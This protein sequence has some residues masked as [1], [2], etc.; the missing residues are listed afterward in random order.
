MKKR[1]ISLLLV[2]VMVLSMFPTTVFAARTG[3]TAPANQANPF[4]D[5]PEGTWFYDAV[6]YS[7][8]NGFFKGTSE[9][10]FDP[11]G[12]MTRGMFVTVLGRMAGVDPDDYKGE[13]EF[14]DV[15]EH[16]YYAPYIKWAARYGITNGTGAGMFAPDVFVNR[17]QM[18]T[19]F[20]RYLETFDVDYQ[21][22]VNITTL[23]EDLD[24]VSPY[25][26][27]AVLKLWKLGLL[28][29]DGI[30]F[31]PIATS[32]RAQIATLCMRTD[33]TVD[34]WYKEPGVIGRDNR[35]T[36]TYSVR[37][38]DGDRLID[39]LTAEEGEPLGAVPAV[40]KSSKANAILLGYFTDP[41]C[42]Q[43]FYA[44]NPVTGDMNVYAKY[45]E[46]G[47][48]EVLNF[49]SFAQMDQTPD[50]SFEVVGT[51]DPT[52]AITLEVKDGSDP[53]ALKFEATQG[54]YIVSAEGGFNEGCS[55]ELHLAD[56]WTFKDKPETVRTA[57]FSIAMEQV[58]N[59][60]MN[61]DIIYILDTDAIDYT[62]AGKTY[63][64]LTSE[65]ITELG[66]TFAYT[67][68]P[69]E[70][71]D[72]L[73][74]Y[75]GTHPEERNFDGDVLDP[76]YY[77]KVAAVN[78]FDITFTSLG[79]NDF[80]KLYN[81]P[82]NFPLNVDALPTETTGTVN[83]SAL[84]EEVYV[85]AQGEGYDLAMAKTLIG[86]GDFIS[87]FVSKDEITTEDDVYFGKITA[88]NALT[89]E[90]TY[91][92]TTQQ[93]ILDSM[94]LYQDIDVSGDDLITEE[95]KAE[96]EA[97]ILSQIQES[98]FAE[99]AAYMLA[100]MV[101]KTDGFKNA[102]LQSLVITDGK[103]N[104]ISPE[105][106]Q[107]MN[108]GK[109]FELT[110]DIKLTV[111]LITKGDQLRYENGTQLAVG[112][113]AEFEVELEDD[114]KIAIE[115]NATFV[116]EVVVSPRI[117]ASL[118]P[119]I[120]LTMPIPVGVKVTSTVDIKSFTAFSFEATVYTVAPEDE[121]LWDQF[122]DVMTNPEKLAD[123]AGLP[124]ELS[125]G[126]RTA[127]DVLDKIRQMED[128]LSKM[129]D[130][131]EGTWDTIQA[132]QEDIALLWET[133]DH[134][135]TEGEYAAITEALDQTNITSDLLDMMEMTNE[136]GL[137]TEYYESI[138]ALMERYCEMIEKETDWI[139]LLEQDI[140][141]FEVC[142]FGVAIGVDVDFM[143]RADMSLAIGSNLQYEVGK[144]YEFWFKVAPRY[145]RCG[146]DTMDLLDE[147][148]AF[149][150]YVMGRLGLKAGI[151]AKVECGIGSCAAANVG[152]S[153]ELGPYFK[154]WGFFV[155]EYE[156]YRPA[157]TDDWHSAQRMAGALLMEFGLY[158]KMAFEAEAINGLF[159][160]EYEFLDEEFPILSIGTERFY[161]QP[162]YE[163]AEDE[164]LLIKDDDGNSL[165]G[166]TMTLPDYT[167]AL[168][169][170]SMRQGRM[171]IEVKDYSNFIYS[172]SNPNFAID[173]ETGL[174]SVNV[175]EGI[176]YME[177]DLT[178]TYKYGKLAFSTFDMS[179]TVPLVWTNLTDAELSEYYTASVRVGNNTDGYTTVWSQ[180]VLK[181]QEFDLPSVEEIQK[182]IGW[183]EYKYDMGTGYGNQQTEGL[184]LI[185]NEVY[186]FDIGYD[187][188]AITV[189]D[190]E[191]ETG[192]A[193]FYAGY[194]EAFDF[195]AL[196]ATGTTDYANGVFTKFS[197]LTAPEGIDLTKAIDTRM[198]DALAKG[199]TAKANYV[200]NS[201]TATFVFSGIDAE[202]VTVKLRRGDTPTLTAVEAI[203][204]AYG[205]AIKDITPA[206]T[207]ITASTVYQVICGEL[208]TA[209]ATITFVEN[210]GSDV[211]D[212]T[213]P[214]GSIIGTLPTP[215]KTG[216]TFGGWYKDEALTDLFTDTRMPEG[217]ITLYAKWTA[218]RYTV[219]FNENGGNKLD[220]D[221]ITVTYG[222][223]YGQLPKPERS[224]YGFIGWFTAANGGQQVTAQSIYSIEGNQTLYAQWRELKE[225]S[226][227][228]FNF[229]EDETFTYQKD[230]YRSAVYTFNPA[231]GE[232]YTQGE[233]KFE[234][235]AEG[236]ETEGYVDQPME[237]GIWGVKIS[238]PADDFYAKFEVFYSD[239]LII[240]RATR[241]T[242]L[243]GIMS[244]RSLDDLYRGKTNNGMTYL[245]LNLIPNDWE[246]PSMDDLYDF[247]NPLSYRS[248]DASEGMKVTLYAYPDGTAFESI[249]SVEPVSVSKECDPFDVIR[250]H[251]L[252]PDTHYEIYGT[253]TNDR[254]FHDS[255]FVAIIVFRNYKDSARTEQPPTGSIT[256]TTDNE[257]I[258]TYD[259]SWYNET[260]TEFVI[261]TAAELAGVAKLVNDKT[262]NFVGKTIKLDADVDLSA[263]RWDPIG[264]SKNTAFAGIFD[265]QGH[266]VSG[267]Y[268]NDS[269]VEF[270]GLF[271]YVVGSIST[272]FDTAKICNVVIDDSWFYGKSRVGAVVGY[273]SVGEVIN[274]VNYGYVKAYQRGSGDDYQSCAGGIV[275]MAEIGS[276]GTK[277][278][279]AVVSNCVNYGTVYSEGRLTG[280]IVGYAKKG[281]IICNNVNFGSVTGSSRVGGIV[282]CME[283]SNTETLNNYNVGNVRPNDG[284]N[285]YIGAIVG[286]NVDDD[287][288][289]Q[290][291]YYLKDC[292]KGG[293][294]KSRYAMGKDGGSVADGSKSYYASSFEKPTSFLAE[295]AG[296]Y[297]TGKILIDALNAWV[298]SESSVNFS[299]IPVSWEAAENGG[300]PL[301]VGTLISALRK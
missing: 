144:R 246:N 113:E 285:D 282:G 124:S 67:D 149:Q 200:D 126:L 134:V 251:D 194:G 254:N 273:I 270:V 53:V 299:G 137:S 193:T 62:V 130:T 226:N 301:P 41:E 133:I 77:V 243:L 238:R 265:G 257:T 205:M 244:G 136:T 11:S 207:P 125:E 35:V 100:D 1:L 16:T 33:Q 182:L 153:I 164:M 196:D 72:I 286:R 132:Y 190:V 114:E 255:D 192:S 154:L 229:G 169:Y 267:L 178:V 146:Y 81:I 37:F 108:L 209:S 8:I 135:I 174:I 147:R 95:E 148:F 66:G 34:I 242:V 85:M 168:D 32:N 212:I 170:L 214:Y 65:L 159:S 82:D 232:T 112:V 42:T 180:R 176:R 139:T 102:N 218:N 264:T 39:T 203:V 247:D 187:T 245:E 295:S 183:N 46:M 278:I 121:S 109:P 71:G 50:I 293:N 29:G 233:F 235:I 83:I 220:N 231:S 163:P 69:V 38:Y 91:E 27:D 88:Y 19:F 292:A 44:E 115:L 45:E 208:N 234:Y 219:I 25:A 122:K 281:N 7:Y 211:E 172:V 31:T 280:G 105:E 184:T 271:G 175:P 73:C 152:V 222:E 191:N 58:E 294:G 93:E 161:Y 262:D 30:N 99:D 4:V 111:E 239:V 9:T 272:Y 269:S 104:Q 268:F 129:K 128:E 259:I 89:G 64:M 298:D 289:A 94:D 204:D 150:F 2:F 52:Q 47:A 228:V 206:I 236:Y 195:S 97:I 96:I 250:I 78:G 101:S 3:K 118:F 14:S 10:T 279:G 40:E 256:W 63:E 17:E 181:N 80:L 166:V 131:A 223:A 140:C 143:V 213:K 177:C 198:A 284:S 90:I 248:V 230:T 51:G 296:T 160:Y 54:G 75:T 249:N 202:D 225:I 288:I 260:D 156:K 277:D 179:V 275:G 49:T 287:G 60:Q 28:I 185:D 215:S 297:G 171:A 274:C 197:E 21:T 12:T 217:G 258:A 127:G 290:F 224:G 138:E 237:A 18:A 300:Y 189:T 5:V 86:V 141:A 26:R 36:T 98:G 87:L 22:D 240:E 70:P 119:H 59:L 291:N 76:A 253:F 23:P 68:G 227:T 199:V 158:L 261:D 20:V 79:D 120:N 84:D 210:G 43:P 266:T 188:Y 57:A 13:T 116:Q 92:Q 201:V 157:N 56:G 74:I 107:L 186:D 216:H 155:Y 263:F 24:S 55:Y 165:N 61:D 252:Q 15:P 48:A 110:D 145:F 173:S 103:G 123:I 117:K 142:V 6:L 151:R 283:G 221:R 106:L 162:H 276:R 241:D 167:L